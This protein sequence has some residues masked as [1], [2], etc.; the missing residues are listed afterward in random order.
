MKDKMKEISDYINECMPI[1]V[2]ITW[3][4]MVAVVIK[5]LVSPI[6]R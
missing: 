1:V 2:L 5:I 6:T 4:C 3:L